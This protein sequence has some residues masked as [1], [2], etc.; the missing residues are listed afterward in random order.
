L[1]GILFPFDLFPGI[2]RNS[3]LFWSFLFATVGP[4]IAII[5]YDSIKR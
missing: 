1:V 4:A 3:L 2:M 5:G